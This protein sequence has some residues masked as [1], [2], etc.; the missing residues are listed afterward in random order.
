MAPFHEWGSTTSRPLQEDSLLFT[1][2]SAGV[3]GSH[4]IDLGRLKC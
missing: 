1:N 4:L 2:K 3:P